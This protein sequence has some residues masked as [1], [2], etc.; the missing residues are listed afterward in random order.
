MSHLSPTNLGNHNLPPAS[1]C[2]ASSFIRHYQTI[3]LGVP[4]HLCEIQRGF[5]T[6]GVRQLLP[7]WIH[8]RSHQPL[9]K[10]IHGGS[11]IHF[12]KMMAL[13]KWKRTNVKDV[14][15]KLKPPPSENLGGVQDSKRQRLSL[16]TLDF[17]SLGMWICLGL[18][19]A[20][21]RMG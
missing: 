4:Q 19:H 18:V 6:L 8:R 16:W 1:L 21:W 3:W 12:E 15:K 11:A 14:N 2:L 7:W 13:S 10:R 20:K 5:S 17:I 9:L